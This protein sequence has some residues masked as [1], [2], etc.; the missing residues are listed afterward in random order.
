MQRLFVVD[1]GGRR[2]AG[3]EVIG[4]LNVED[5]QTILSK[6][7]EHIGGYKLA[8]SVFSGME[9]KFGLKFPKYLGSAN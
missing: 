9:S 5:A 4:G 1:F 3:S 6:N 2:P 8:Q 7:P